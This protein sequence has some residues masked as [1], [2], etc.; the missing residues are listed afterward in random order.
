MIR[1]GHLQVLVLFPIP[2][3]AS[4][5]YRRS[6]P[7][8]WQS[9][10]PRPLVNIHKRSIGTGRHRHADAT[11]TRPDYPM[12]PS[13]PFKARCD[14]LARA[15]YLAVIALYTSLTPVSTPIFM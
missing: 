8:T 11:G 2:E 5:L 3:S 10:F 9:A 1:R 7:K 13:N 6:L 4:S 12:A 15:M 14:V